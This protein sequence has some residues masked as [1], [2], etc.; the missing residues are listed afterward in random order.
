MKYNVITP[1]SRFENLKKLISMLEPMNVDWHVIMDDDLPFRIS[2][3][4]KWIHPLHFPKTEGAFWS[5]WQKSLNWFFSNIVPEEDSRYL[6][7]ND[8]DAYEPDFFTKLDK[9]SGDVIICS[10]KRGDRI[11]PVSDPVRAHPTSTLIA[12]P[13]NMVVCGVG[14]QQIVVGGKIIPQMKLEDH[15]YADGML[16]TNIVKNNPAQ[17]AP[18]VFV[19]FNY[20]EPGRWDK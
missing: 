18:E 15:V 6:I 1:L 16:I 14:A 8:D 10:M 9:Y 13:E 20:F 5:T 17:Y 3:L 19:W 2:F 11:P 12:V 4:K 7:L